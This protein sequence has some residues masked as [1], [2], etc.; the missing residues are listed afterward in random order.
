MP[1]QCREFDA[2]QLEILW[3]RLISIVDEAAKAIK[4]TAFSTLSNEAK[5]GNFQGRQRVLEGRCRQ[6]VTPPIHV[7]NPN[8]G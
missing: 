3:T 2:V 7:G 5:I 4:R 1:G 6:H 8:F